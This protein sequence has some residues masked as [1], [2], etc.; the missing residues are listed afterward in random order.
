MQLSAATGAIQDGWDAGKHP[1]AAIAL[2]SDGSR[3]VLAGALVDVWDPAAKARVLRFSGHAVRNVLHTCGYACQ[4]R[5][6][7]DELHARPFSTSCRVPVVAGKG[8]SVHSRWDTCS[9][10]WVGGT[11]PRTLGRFRSTV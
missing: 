2:S 9:N 1:L 7:L 10:C 4:R 5:V 6:L 11:D 3:A 8:S